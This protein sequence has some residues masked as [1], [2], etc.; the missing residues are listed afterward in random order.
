VGQPDWAREE[1]ERIF[2]FFCSFYFVNSFQK[3]NQK[4]FEPNKFWKNSLKY[5][6]ILET[7]F[8]FVSQ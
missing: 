2:P 8:E 1:E 4:L 3:P 5:F 6:E 7:K